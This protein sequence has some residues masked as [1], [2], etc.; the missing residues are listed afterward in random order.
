M[1]RWGRVLAGRYR[2]EAVLG[3][4]AS[5]QCTGHSTCR[6][7]PNA[8]KV[9]HAS[10]GADDDAHAR[11]ENEGRVIAQLFH[12]NIVEMLEFGRDSDGTPLLGDGAPAGLDAA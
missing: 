4:G 11:F 8:T 6:P 12:P 2:I 9:L 3:R 1:G 7:R 5:A 10:L